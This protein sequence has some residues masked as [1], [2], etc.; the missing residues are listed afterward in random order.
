MSE[1]FPMY[2]KSAVAVFLIAAVPVCAH[3]QQIAPPKATKADAERVV[4]II[5]GDKAKTQQFCELA[6]LDDQIGEAESKKDTKKVEELT[7][8][9]GG[10]EQKLGP[11]YMSFMD[12]VQQV[13]PNSAEGKEIT[14]V[15][16][17][18]DKLCK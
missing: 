6:K 2:L 9:L 13:D 11:E 8:Q 4:K 5:S 1:E 10:M 14:T 7:Q 16:D 15:L 3:A 17:A 18:L 12:G